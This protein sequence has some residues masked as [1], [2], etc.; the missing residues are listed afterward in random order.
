[1][2]L[3][4]NSKRVIKVYMFCFCWLF[5]LCNCCVIPICDAFKYNFWCIIGIV[6]VFVL[7]LFCIWYIEKFDFKKLNR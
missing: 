1:M 6:I 7:D 3:S 5:V 2:K 4:E